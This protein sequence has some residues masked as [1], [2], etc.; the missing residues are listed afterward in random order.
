M[1][2]KYVPSGTK[3]SETV[4]DITRAIHE[5]SSGSASL[6]NLE[7]CATASSSL[8]AGT[9]S[10]WSLSSGY[11]LATGAAGANDAQYLLEASS[12][13]GSNKMYCSVHLN[14]NWANSS[15]YNGNYG[16]Y[17]SGYGWVL[18]GLI[19]KGLSTEM[20]TH[21][22]SG[23]SASYS[24][25]GGFS[26]YPTSG[27]D[28]TF[29]VFAGAKYIV[30][31]GTSSAG[32]QWIMGMTE[33]EDNYMTA[34]ARSSISNA[35]PH[36]LFGIGSYTTNSGVATRAVRYRGDLDT[37]SPGL[38]G[39]VFFRQFLQCVKSRSG[40]VARNYAPISGRWNA[41]GGLGEGLTE[42]L[43]NT[44]ENGTTTGS[45]TPNASIGAYDIYEPSLRYMG[46]ESAV[47]MNPYGRT[48]SS[49][50]V[51]TWGNS[52]GQILSKNTAGNADQIPLIPLVHS[53]DH[54]HGGLVMNLSKYMPLY[55]CPLDLGTC[56]DT[57]TVGSDTYIYLGGTWRNNIK[58]GY[59]MK[60]E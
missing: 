22:Y 4:R 37:Y 44:E 16:V 5:S 6:N 38:D 58:T 23:T 57:F 59:M 46:L 51:S 8:T 1:Y 43:Y 49:N 40:N 28:A 54:I 15:I 7:F 41:Q 31:S 53:F 48:Y 13:I 26:Y 14:G 32:N 39:P 36:V 9:N 2:L 17:N 42:R 20:Y 47:T 45:T 30:V 10:G 35:V 56:G 21:G 3:V 18:S 12:S 19:D 24:G 55:L 27:Y 25:A 50:Q 34:D 60:V 29:H 52:Y 11:S 33:L